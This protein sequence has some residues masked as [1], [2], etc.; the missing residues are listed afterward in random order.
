[1]AARNPISGEPT[2]LLTC[3]AARCPLPSWSRTFSS[4]DALLEHARQTRAQHP[5]CTTCLRVFKDTAALEQHVEAKHVVVCQ[6]CNRKY[7]SQSAIDQ[8]WRSS[9]AHPNCPVCGAGA[10]DTTALA[11]HIANAH[12]KVR[13]CGVLLGENDLDVHYLTSRNHPTC[14]ECNIG[15]ATELEYAEHNS[16]LHSDLQCK[17]CAE[18]FS[19]PEALR[20]HTGD[21]S[22]HRR[23][24]FCNAEFK[25]TSALV[26]HYTYTHLPPNDVQD[27]SSSVIEVS[28]R[29]PTPPMNRPYAPPSRP[30]PSAVVGAMRAATTHAYPPAPPSRTS[31]SGPGA[32]ASGSDI[33]SDLYYSPHTT[34]TFTPSPSLGDNSSSAPHSHSQSYSQSQ[35]P[36]ND[37]WPA[38]ARSPRPGFSSDGASSDYAAG[39]AIHRSAPAALTP[40]QRARASPSPAVLTPPRALS[41]SPSPSP[42]LPIPLR[43]V[44][45][46]G[47]VTPARNGVLI[48]SSSQAH[49]QQWQQQQQQHQR[50]LPQPPS[51]SR[52]KGSVAETPSGD[53]ANFH[54]LKGSPLQSVVDFDTPTPSPRTPSASP[55]DHQAFALA[56]RTGAPYFPLTDGRR[57]LP[58]SAGISPT[59]ARAQ[60]AAAAT[61]D[62]RSSFYCRACQVDPCR[63]IT[64][65]ACGHVFC[66]AC[67]VE[68]VRENA[69]CP[70]CNAAVL[71]FALLRLDVS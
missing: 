15:F 57:F 12:P 69:R 8:H 20:A 24:E 66:N 70:V 56:S 34:N 68:E 37:N 10:A 21:P 22:S 59:F 40:A 46:V 16:Q 54:L 13:C 38:A 65:T 50:R 61:P 35:S 26:E 44:G 41:S 9:G 55:A 23:C 7:K 67:I 64:A 48:A 39:T 45:S 53:L 36:F 1:M 63:E 5:L 58:G 28:T 31:T 4:N 42:P 19:S 25:E 17:V 11:E 6:P 3:P 27:A 71:L 29:S 51:S 52:S 49:E 30:T 2:T 62:A 18:Q 32:S 60:R 14:S 47:P 43:A 33:A